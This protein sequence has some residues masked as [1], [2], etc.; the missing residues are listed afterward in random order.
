VSD[1][2]LDVVTVAGTLPEAAAAAMRL[3]D[4]GLDVLVAMDDGVSDPHEAVEATAAVGR[5]AGL[6]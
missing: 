5:A 4:A 2:L 6:L 3:A 1:E